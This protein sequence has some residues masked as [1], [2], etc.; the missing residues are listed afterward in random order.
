MENPVKKDIVFKNVTFGNS[1]SCKR[2]TINLLHYTNNV[3]NVE[4]SS[5]T[6]KDEAD[7]TIYITKYVIPFNLIMQCIKLSIT[8]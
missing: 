6:L 8:Q 7:R 3:F 5:I 1:V 2:K 4:E